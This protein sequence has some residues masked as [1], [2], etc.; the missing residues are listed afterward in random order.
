MIL[1]DPQTARQ[2]ITPAGVLAGAALATVMIGLALEDW[3][4]EACERERKAREAAAPPPVETPRRP[5]GFNR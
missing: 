4:T 2:A 1:R 5:I 3:H